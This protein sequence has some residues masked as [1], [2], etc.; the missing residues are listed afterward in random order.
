MGD[1]LTFPHPRAGITTAVDRFIGRISAWADTAYSVRIFYKSRQLLTASWLSFLP[2]NLGHQVVVCDGQHGLPVFVADAMVGALLFEG[3]AQLAAAK[4]E[5]FML[6]LEATALDYL[7]SWHRLGGIKSAEAGLLL[8]SELERWSMT[9]HSSAAGSAAASPVERSS[10]RLSSD[11]FSRVAMHSHSRDILQ[12]LAIDLHSESPHMAL[13]LHSDLSAAVRQDPLRL[14]QV[15]QATVF[16]PD[17]HMLDGRELQALMA[18][19]NLP[20]SPEAGSWVIGLTQSPESLLESR[21]IAREQLYH[22]LDPIFFLD[23]ETGRGQFKD[24]SVRILRG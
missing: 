6:F 8:K 19:L 7:Q 1:V 21:R 11:W 9:V 20:P 24:W 17:L 2:T 18:A 4:H 5:E 16:V 12:K 3:Y 10:D 22:V 14:R 13:L 15:E 23:H